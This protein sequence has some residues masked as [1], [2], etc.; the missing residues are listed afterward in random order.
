VPGDGKVFIDGD[1]SQIELVVLA[2]ILKYQFN[3]GSS[4]HD[5]I[6][7][8][9][10]I[11][12]IIAAAVL[13]KDI[14]EVTK[15]ERNSVKPVSFGCPGGMG[16]SGL[17]RYAKN[18][19][20]Q[21]L[22]V[23]EVQE[24]INAYHRLCPELRPFLEDEVASGLVIAQTLGLTPAAYNEGIGSPLPASGDGAFVP[25]G[26]LAGMLFKALRDP[27]PVKG[28][29][30]PFSP[31]EIEFFWLRAQWLANELP[32]KLA[33][34]LQNREAGNDLHEAVRNLFSR[35]SVFTV[36]GR[37]RANTLFGASRNT[38]FQGPAADGAILGMWRLWRAGY[39]LVSAI[40]DQ[41]VI[42]CDGDDQVLERKADIERLMIQGMLAVVPVMNV[43]VETVV[44][45]SLNKGELDTRYC[46]PR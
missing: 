8:G 1:Y 42:E 10:D 5:L 38:P 3:L 37:L 22:S 29:G 20:K 46:G 17:Q 15:A 24:R 7:A 26:W 41:V 18:S 36:T 39:K 13:D 23:E 4:L 45:R 40:H 32:A 12:R 14:A 11:H 16:V 43:R 2:Y 9:S 21:E 44:S 25:Q 6:N 28:S 31:A 33:A 27:Q 35:R 19:F 34:K 30:V